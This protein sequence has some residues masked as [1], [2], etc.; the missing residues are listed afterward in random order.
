MVKRIALALLIAISSLGV[1]GHAQKT[2]SH[3]GKVVVVDGH[4]IEFVGKGKRDHILSWR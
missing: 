4:P 1:P 3:G 2:G